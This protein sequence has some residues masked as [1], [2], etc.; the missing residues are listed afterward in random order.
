MLE[1]NDPKG[2]I[3][4]VDDLADNLDLLC[5]ILTGAGYAV[6]SSTSSLHALQAVRAKPCDLILLDIRM[7][8]M[9]GLA[10]CRHLK[11]DPTLRGIPVIFISALTSIEEKVQAFEAGGVDYLT[12]PFQ[13]AEVLVR[14]RT[15]LS[16]YRMQTSLEALVAERSSDLLARTRDLERQIEERRKTE[17]ALREAEFRYRTVADF[18]YAWEYW[19][20]PDGGLR[21]IS[22]SCERVTGYPPEMF[23]SNPGLLHGIV[24]EEDRP[25]WEAHRLEA[26]AERRAREQELRIRGADGRI[27]HIEHTCQ[28]VLGDDGS[29]LGF[30]VS[31]RDVSARKELERELLQA[32]KME[33]IGTLAGGIAHDFNNILV[34]I[35]GY[36]ELAL[37]LPDNSPKAREYLEVVLE[38]A[39]RAKD[40][41][42]QILTFSRRTAQEL[43]PLQVSLIIKEALKLLRASLPPSIV[44]R[45]HV[46]ATDLVLADPT[47]VHQVI[48][49]LCTNA[50]HAMREAGGTLAVS[51]RRVTLQED[52]VLQGSGCP[53]G[54]YLLLEVADTGHG[55]DA[56]TRARIFDPYF[57]TKAAGEGTGLGLAVVSGIVRNLKGHIAVSSEV[58]AGATFRIYLPVHVPKESFRPAPAEEDRTVPR[59]SEAGRIMAVDDDEKVVTVIRGLLEKAGF[60]VLAFTGG[61]EALSFFCRNPSGVDLVVTD[62]S[63]PGYSGIE[64][65]RRLLAIRPELPVILCTGHHE[66]ISE[67]MTRKTGFFSGYIQKP[68]AAAGLLALVRKTL[69]EKGGR[70][71]ADRLPPISRSL[72]GSLTAA[73]AGA[74]PAR[75]PAPGSRKDPGPPGSG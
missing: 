9:D 70:R 53:L 10:M 55:M 1:G 18:T 43:K 2:S 29:F 6:R 32:Q 44:I 35:F 3:L 39:Q 69:R 51:L 71:P 21:Y 62:L 67:E 20:G 59:L 36:A 33:A 42:R 5:A 4:V 28:P 46:A 15:H 38:S 7:P 61:R 72:L 23:R 26:M 37:G 40:L 73:G 14:V 17:E 12:K 34:G 50:F 52:A 58:G 74:A 60:T 66:A 22:P 63:M 16:L 45:Q 64:L 8:E 75:G 47:Q 54:D 19:E 11:E 31:N 24:L 49:N 41:V 56:T 27:R 65:A 13:A 57:T 48:M 25:A 30:R 68:F